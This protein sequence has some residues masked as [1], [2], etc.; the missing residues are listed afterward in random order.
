[1]VAVEADEEAAVGSDVDALAVKEKRRRAGGS[2]AD[3]QCSLL[4]R[5]AYAEARLRLRCRLRM[6][7]AG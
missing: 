5:L 7:L 2:M 3:N 4:Q 1:M 6:R